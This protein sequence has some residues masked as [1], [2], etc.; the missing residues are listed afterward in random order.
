MEDGVTIKDNKGNGI[1][2]SST[3][4]FIMNG[5][6]IG[7]NEA[8]SDNGGGV[9]VNGGKLTMSG[10]KISGNSAPAPSRRL[11]ALRALPPNRQHNAGQQQPEQ[12][13]G[14]WRF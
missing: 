8:S 1:V 11:D 12:L 4:E 2:I 13:D 10:G 7:G 6:E 9:Y 3:G 5:G 14:D